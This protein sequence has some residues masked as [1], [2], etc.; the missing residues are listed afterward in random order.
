MGDIYYLFTLLYKSLLLLLNLSYNCQCYDAMV[1]SLSF[2]QIELFS[3]KIASLYP[4][5]NDPQHVKTNKMTIVPSE[6]SDQP[7][8]LPSVV[9]HFY[10]ISNRY[11]C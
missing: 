11:S 4:H 7:G 2:G 9:F 5:R 3:D 6:D 10:S 1:N 8:H